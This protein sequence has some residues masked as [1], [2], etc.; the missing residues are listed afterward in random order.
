MISGHDEAVERAIENSKNIG[1]KR[2]LKLTVS[3]PFHCSLMQPASEEMRNHLNN[4]KTVMSKDMI[5]GPILKQIEVS[6]AKNADIIWNE[7]QEIGE[8]LG[9]KDKREVNGI[10]LPTITAATA[11]FLPGTYKQGLELKK[12]V[13]NKNATN[14]ITLTIILNFIF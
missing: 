3:A 6:F 10:I 8:T 11:E 12:Y 5:N 9:L 2:A 4:L 14:T 7:F 13:E 1:I